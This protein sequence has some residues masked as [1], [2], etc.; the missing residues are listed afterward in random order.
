[1][2]VKITTIFFDLGY[3]LI[4]FKGNVD[5]VLFS[6]YLALSDSLISSG[7]SH[8]R[9]EYARQYQQIISRYYASRDI[10]NL[11]QPLE[12]FVN[13]ALS[14]FGY[15]P[16]PPEITTKAI[17][18]M[19]KIT[20]AHWSVEKDTH[21]TLARLKQDGYHLCI[22]SNASNTDDL[23]NLIDQSGLRCYFD[24]IIISAEEKIRKPH[25]KIFEIALRKMKANPGESIM[26]GDTL[27]AD[28]LGAQ[29]AGMRAI[30]VTRRAN[31]PENNRM[32]KIITPDFST[33]RLKQL[34]EIINSIK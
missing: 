13:R 33:N 4:N 20:E 9:R 32:K 30:W 11:E 3:T 15:S 23:N 24:Q 12:L 5:R 17:A 2:P 28:V 6:S 29:K 16:A 18:A 26:V 7:Y 19:F 21:P 22:I 25:P 27:I 14:G 31:R 34:P 8:N 1:M 10:D